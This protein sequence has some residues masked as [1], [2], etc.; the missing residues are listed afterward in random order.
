[1][2]GQE[3]VI[4]KLKAT[5]ARSVLL[6]GPAHWG[7]KTLLRELFSNEDAVFEITGNA[8]TFRNTLDRIYLNARPTIY[9]I[10]DVDKCN[11]TIQNMLLKVLEEPPLSSRFFLTAS[12]SILPTITSR[13]VTYRMEPYSEY[14]IG[15]MPAQPE[16]IGMFNSPGQLRLIDT[17]NMPM[18]VRILKEIRDTCMSKPLS[19]M[20]VLIK[21]VD[22]MLAEDGS[23]PEAFTL[24]CE[25]I[26]G[27]CDTMDW[28]RGQPNDNAK[29]VRHTFIMK[30]WLE[31]QVKQ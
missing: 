3:N 23:S 9:I 27:K 22:R 20:L 12:G 14:I 13:C 6:T 8:S 1:M 10:P 31:R 11:L 30:Y 28:L 17:P 15:N 29:Y 21:D 19:F 4:A 16:L 7:K 5:R 26:F 25:D 24:V 18:V 2:K